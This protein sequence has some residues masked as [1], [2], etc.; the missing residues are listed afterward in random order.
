[1]MTVLR[2]ELARTF[3]TPWLWVL[4]AAFFLIAAHAGAS[5]EAGF[6]NFIATT[7]N[8][9]VNVAGLIGISSMLTLFAWGP[10]FAR[11]VVF[12]TALPFS[13]LFFSMPFRAAGYVAGKSAAALAGFL[14]P[15]VATVVGLFLGTQW[16]AAGQAALAPMTIAPYLHGLL[17][18][19][20][21]NALF[22]AGVIFVTASRGRSVGATYFG[23]VV[24]FLLHALT[25]I[26]LIGNSALQDILD[27]FGLR[28]FLSINTGSTV[29]DDKVWT[30][31][32]ND[33]GFIANRILWL[34]ISFGLLAFGAWRLR[35]PRSLSTRDSKVLEVEPPSSAPVSS[36][37]LSPSWWTQVLAITRF[38]FRSAA[39]SRAYLVALGVGCLLIAMN[40]ATI[41][42]V[43]TAV[44]VPTTQDVASVLTGI[45]SQVLV[46]VIVFLTLELA[47]HDEDHGSAGLWGALPVHPGAEA[48]GKG[49]ALVGLSL[50]FVLAGVA[51]G[52]GVLALGAPSLFEPGRLVAPAIVAIALPLLSIVGTLAVVALVQSR[53]VALAIIGAVLG[54]RLLV[55]ALGS[56]SHL[57]AFG[58]LPPLVHSE[59]TGYG[60]AFQAW[61][62][63]ALAWSAVVAGLLM[64]ATWLRDKS[65]GV[66]W[67]FAMGLA[68]I[69]LVAGAVHH[70]RA[71][72]LQ[73]N[74]FTGLTA[75]QAARYELGY[76]ASRG[77]T[78]PTVVD[79]TS[80]IEL[81]TVRHSA[82]ATLRYRVV[83]E[84]AEPIEAIH[85]DWNPL[86]AVTVKG[87]F[88]SSVDPELGTASLRPASALA[89]GASLEIE[90]TSTIDRRAFDRTGAG[91]AERSAVVVRSALLL[92][93][94]G[95][96]RRK[97]VDGAER[98][99]R[100]GLASSS[101]EGSGNG[102]VDN[103]LAMHFG[104]SRLDT[105]VAIDGDLLAIA[106]GELVEQ[107]R[108]GARQVFRYVTSAP[109]LPY[110]A[111]VA[112]RWTKDATKAGDMTLEIFHHAGHDGNLPAMRA[113]AKATL[114]YGNEHYGSLGPSSL[115]VIEVPRQLE[116]PQALPGMMILPESVGFLFDPKAMSRDWTTMLVAHE[117]AHQWW[118]LKV[119]P[120]AGKGSQVLSE[121]LAQMTAFRVLRQMRSPDAAWFVDQ[122]RGDYLAGRQRRT[123]DEPA[124]ADADGEPYLTYS[125]GPV[126]LEDIARSLGERRFND[127]IGR[128][129]RDHGRDY[130][131]T[132]DLMEALLVEAG[133]GEA[134][135]IRNAFL[136]PGPG[137]MSHWTTPAARKNSP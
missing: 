2:F 105:T 21:P 126:L 99:A 41:P 53:A 27:P 63:Y 106:P 104:R 107:R 122:A 133:E 96:N 7:V 45:F 46:V 59:I 3:R 117:T 93:G 54:L 16:D 29:L 44:L 38:H 40:S 91:L 36:P 103:F 12:D 81:D 137:D 68:L 5:N 17:V 98:R 86:V 127:A 66:R 100:L 74:P 71:S 24:L 4:S 1:M 102:A 115:R 121:S 92:P 30:L 90:L 73:V 83:N 62:P 10:V 116:N 55:T 72:R 32:I 51:V 110:F 47:F 76:G 94:L 124:L 109:V 97:E 75:E 34:S 61:S 135:R 35:S 28:S 79:I 26:A 82:S 128:F 22:G 134:D 48:V 8:A 33:G 69:V 50:L 31:T 131:T 130:P 9:P 118:A 108:E 65:K 39:R 43:P 20:L 120:A 13:P 101:V 123:G 23:L 70:V 11:S 113:A 78:E 19:A 49:A 119:V 15:S 14:L 80:R 95:Y 132:R 111:V 37:T 85:L 64:L 87:S 25:A 112:G 136:S 88:A 77:A 114:L 42:G 89:P 6:A 60:S 58:W 67:S 57:L 129:V 125:K 84:S 56:P 18:L 52:A